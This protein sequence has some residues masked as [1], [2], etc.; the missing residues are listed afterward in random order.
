MLKLIEIRNLETIDTIFDDMFMNE[1][2]KSLLKNFSGIP[3]AAASSLEKN[4]V[5]DEG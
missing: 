3:C 2:S 4:L 5:D 1:P